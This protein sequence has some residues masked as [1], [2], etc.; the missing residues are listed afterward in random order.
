[1]VCALAVS[2]GFWKLRSLN[3][4]RQSFVETIL[5]MCAFFIGT[6]IEYHLTLFFGETYLSGVRVP[7]AFFNGKFKFKKKM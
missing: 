5:Y 4:I 7:E 6:N 2:F 1:M 3:T